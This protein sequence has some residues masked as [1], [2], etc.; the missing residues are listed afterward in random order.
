MGV[1]MDMD[2]DM[3]EGW[4]KEHGCLKPRYLNLY[5]PPGAVSM[6]LGGWVGGD[7]GLSGEVPIPTPHTHHVYFFPSGSRKCQ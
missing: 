5:I 6:G 3:L 7:E 2:M 1:D 4:W